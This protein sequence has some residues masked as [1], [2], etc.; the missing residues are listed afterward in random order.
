M[1]GDDAGQERSMN[2]T[3]VYML[4][5][6]SEK[7][8]MSFILKSEG[9]LLVV[10]GGNTCDADYLCAYIK[11][12]GGVVD[13]WFLTHPHHDH[14]DALVSHLERHPDKIKIKH[15][16]YNFPS[17]EFFTSEDGKPYDYRCE[18][19]LE[20]MPKVLSQIEKSAIPTTI[21]HKGDVFE[22]GEMTVTVLH[23]PNEKITTNRVN[24]SSVVY[25][26]DA[27]EKSCIFLGDLGVEGGEELLENTPAELLRADMVQ[28]AHHGNEGVGRAVY[29]A[30]GAKFCL[31]CTTD[32]LWNNDNGLGYDTHIWRTVVTRGW[33]SDIGVK[34]HYISKDGTHEVP[35]NDMDPT[36][37]LRRRKTNRS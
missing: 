19:A 20:T 31:W 12:L 28:L 10:D 32:W 5:S 8:M 23:E 29:D 14:C 11:K 9:H 33:M 22:F 16:Y 7:Q 30:I 6:Q 1:Y 15:I 26:L 35:F 21:V 18:N 27:N 34:W 25:R 13:G 2:M 24:N 3:T 36:V 37:H 17:L 4:E